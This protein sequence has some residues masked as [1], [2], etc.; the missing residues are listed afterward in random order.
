MTK[1][2]IVIT[3]ATGGLA[4]SIIKQLPS[5]DQLILLGRNHSNLKKMYGQR[6]NTDLIEIDIKDDFA[7]Q[8]C[9][10]DIWE[11]YGHIDLLINNAGFGAFKEF[12]DFESTEIE[13]MF[14]VNTIAS[15][16]F[17]R[18]I[19][20]KMAR[21]HSGHIINIVSMAGLIA[22]SKSSIYSATKFAVIGFSNALR[23][24]LADKNVFVTTV[25]PG[26]IRTHFFDKADPSGQ[27]LNSV[28]KLALSPEYVAKKVIAIIGTS[29]REMNLPFIL[30]LTY[31]FYTMFPK[32]SDFLARKVFNYK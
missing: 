18:Y 14:Q 32:L 29:K 7:I 9:V 28:D 30:N 31:K 3:G 24:E 26:P 1:R 19:G 6:P 4:Q 12:D 20:E 23:L 22:S 8:S 13:E 16:H 27:Y 21:V 10:E 25:N 15:I 11:K 5:S 17:S 2:T